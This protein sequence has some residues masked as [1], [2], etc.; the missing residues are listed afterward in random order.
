[1]LSS[2][3]MRFVYDTTVV[4]TDGSQSSGKTR[5]AIFVDEAIYQMLRLQEPVSGFDAE[6]TVVLIGCSSN[7]VS[8]T[9]CVQSENQDI[10]IVYQIPLDR[11]G[12]V[13]HYELYQIVHTKQ[14]PKTV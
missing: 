1:M 14:P 9:R 11:L 8:S 10:R 2:E 5:S 3:A 7:I 12:Y 6:L 13:Q 4:F